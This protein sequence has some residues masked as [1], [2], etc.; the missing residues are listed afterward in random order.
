MSFMSMAQTFAKKSDAIIG[1]GLNGNNEAINTSILRALR[2]GYAKEIKVFDTPRDLVD[3][4]Y[5]GVLTTAIRGS[6]SSAELIPLL[7]R[8]FK[9]RYLLRT[10]IMLRK[11]GS[12]FLL[13]PVGIDEGTSFRARLNFIIYG[14][15]L[16]QY[17]KLP[18]NIAVLSGARPEDHTRAKSLAK[19]LA[20][21]EKLVHTA[22]T[23]EIN[24]KHY[25]VQI[26][27]AIRDATMI[28]APDG[29]AGNLIFRTLYYINGYEAL[30]APALGITDKIYVDTS[31]NK[32]DYTHTIMLASALT[33]VRPRHEV[34]CDRV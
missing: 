18:I 24:A 21:N 32:R 10:A 16:L 3:S 12:P 6:L 19:K 22:L 34:R 29:I 17:F 31:R 2:R 7:K 9:V 26:E 33:W 27:D 20:L 15:E 13:A 14:T 30:G 11:D 23:M 28:L 25:G 5:D 4:L 8:K 1:I